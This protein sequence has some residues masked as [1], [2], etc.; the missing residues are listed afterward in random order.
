MRNIEELSNIAAK[1]ACE[2]A[3]CGPLQ[4]TPIK[5]GKGHHTYIFG[6]EVSKAKKIILAELIKLNENN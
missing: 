1:I 4:K 3:Y 5:G 2:V 6:F